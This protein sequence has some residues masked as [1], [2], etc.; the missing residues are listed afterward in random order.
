M[1]HEHSGLL[2]NAVKIA[3]RTTPLTSKGFSILRLDP[4]NVELIPVRRI[5][6]MALH[7]EPIL[8]R[9]LLKGLEI[10]RQVRDPLVSFDL[11]SGRRLQLGG[12]LDL[13]HFYLTEEFDFVKALVLLVNVRIC[14]LFPPTISCRLQLLSRTQERP[15]VIYYLGLYLLGQ[16]NLFDVIFYVVPHKS[17]IRRTLTITTGARRLCLGRFSEHPLPFKI[18]VWAVVHLVAF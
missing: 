11:E 7:S 9:N 2:T 13:L 8:L 3:I 16:R 17:Q 10:I 4:E 6:S 1:L 15:L 18:R 12:V 14:S 5:D